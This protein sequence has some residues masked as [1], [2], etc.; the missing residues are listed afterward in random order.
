MCNFS[1]K[2]NFSIHLWFWGRNLLQI[3]EHPSWEASIKFQRKMFFDLFTLAYILVIIRLD[4]SSDSSSFIFIR[5]NSSS[6]SFTF[7]YICL[8]SSSDSSVF[9]EQ[10]RKKVSSIQNKCTRL[11]IMLNNRSHYLWEDWIIWELMKDT[12]E[13]QILSTFRLVKVYVFR[14][15]CP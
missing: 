4:L 15:H 13:V 6:D 7:V 12:C 3:K 14:Y 2:T 5:L 10:I 1:V 8:H 11:Y 9:L